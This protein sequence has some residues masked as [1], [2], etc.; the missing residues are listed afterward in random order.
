MEAVHPAGVCVCVCC[1]SEGGFPIIAWRVAKEAAT[2][3]LYSLELSGRAASA[4]KHMRRDAQ[5][6]SHAFRSHTHS[7]HPLTCAQ[8]PRSGG[9]ITPHNCDSTPFL[10]LSGPS[11]TAV[12]GCGTVTPHCA[13]DG[14]KSCSR[15]SSLRSS[16]QVLSSV[17]SSRL[18]PCQR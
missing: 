13:G 11:D 3:R 6:F 10:L 17:T 7:C 14:G 12:C 16:K 15:T 5:S 8:T 2:C 9:R 4:V 1:I 18:P